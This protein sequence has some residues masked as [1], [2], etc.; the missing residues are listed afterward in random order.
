MSKTKEVLQKENV[1]QAVIVADTF[2]DEFVPFSDS[3]PHVR[4]HTDVIN[5]MQKH[6]VISGSF[7]NLKQTV[8]WLYFRVF[9]FGRNRGDFF[10]LLL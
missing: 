10:V 3:L 2:D 6:I 9:I 5:M 4:N 7:T 1:V 8:N